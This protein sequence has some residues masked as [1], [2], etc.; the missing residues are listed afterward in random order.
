MVG[1][2]II[3]LTI[4]NP[5]AAGFDYPHERLREIFAAVH[6]FAYHPDPFGHR[7]ARNAIAAYYAARSVVVAPEQIALTAS[8]SEAY[9]LLLKLL[10]DPGDEILVPSPSYPLFEYLAALECVRVVPYRLLY[11]GNWFVDFDYLRA[12]VSDRT[13]AIVVV[14]PNNPTGSFLKQSE[15]AAL[16][17]LTSFADVPLICDEVFMDYP[18]APAPDLISTLAGSQTGLSFSL[19]GLS[20][21]AGMP[22]MKLGWIVI[23]GDPG[24]RSRAGERLEHVLDTYLSVGTPV[25][26][27]L[28]DLLNAG[29]AVREQIQ[30]R[31]S[32][33][34]GALASLLRGAPVHPLH[35]EGGWSAI[36]QLPNTHS[37][38]HW[39]TTLLRDDGVA[40]QPGYFFDMASEAYAVVSLL[41]PPDKLRFGIE[42]LVEMVGKS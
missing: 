15:Y 9:S 37:E 29:M 39:A 40:V 7:S 11:A 6:D 14:N 26:K 32:A 18:I 36:L 17:E 19:N 16:V 12:V 3:D 5:V 27:A 35:T 22:Q 13:R 10:C 41:T 1:E 34:Y 21:A 8:T 30:Q 25:Q 4:S 33:N 42:R 24:E 31:I 2:P 20:K 38:E 28:P 23:S